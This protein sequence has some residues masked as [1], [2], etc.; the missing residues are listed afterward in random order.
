M[1]MHAGSHTSHTHCEHHGTPQ[2][3]DGR[4]D[5]VPADYNGTVYTCP[6]HLDVRQ[7]EPGSC[8]LCGMAL[9]V[10]GIPQQDEAPIQ[11]LWISHGVLSSAH[12]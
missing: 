10:E 4:Y 5:L 1:N 8:P 12:C 6:M 2:E 9:E 7:P 3:T 11:S